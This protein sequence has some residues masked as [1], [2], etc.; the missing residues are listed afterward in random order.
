MI[1]YKQYLTKDKL[2]MASWVIQALDI[3][4]EKKYIKDGAKMDKLVPGGEAGMQEFASTMCKNIPSHF[5]V[6]NGFG[7][8]MTYSM[9]LGMLGVAGMEDLAGEIA[10]Q[11]LNEENE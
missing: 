2:L 10:E 1:D 11:R 8:R 7:Y 4:L 5:Y 6:A 9:L 3:E